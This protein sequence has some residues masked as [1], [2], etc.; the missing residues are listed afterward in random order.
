MGHYES[1][2]QSHNEFDLPTLV[3]WISKVKCPILFTYGSNA[4]TIF[5]QFD[6]QVAVERK[7]PILRGGGTRIRI[8]HYA[9]INW[10]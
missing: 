9:K 10:P 8:E 3:D 4:K 7:V 1:A 6:W 5:P 2:N